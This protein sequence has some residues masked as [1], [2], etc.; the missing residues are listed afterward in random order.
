MYAL[1]YKNREFKHKI[2]KNIYEGLFLSFLNYNLPWKSSAIG[3]N[4][5]QTEHH[6]IKIYP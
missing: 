6:R 5:K 4:L 1:T 3:N 2:T